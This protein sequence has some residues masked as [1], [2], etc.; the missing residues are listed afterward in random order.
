MSVGSWIDYLIYE[1]RTEFAKEIICGYP[2]PAA[3][4][5]LNGEVFIETALE[6]DDFEM[7]EWLR[8]YFKNYKKEK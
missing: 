2:E 8:D 5:S 3:E 7:A 1:G 4:W 6:Y